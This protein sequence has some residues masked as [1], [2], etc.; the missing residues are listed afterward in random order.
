MFTL[1]VARPDTIKLADSGLI[2]ELRR[3]KRGTER[4]VFAQNRCQ[5]SYLSIVAWL[6]LLSER[7]DSL[8]G[9]ASFLRDMLTY[10]VTL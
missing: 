10:C 8:C 3:H 2:S 7:C 6:D 5:A 1:N 9:V 4:T